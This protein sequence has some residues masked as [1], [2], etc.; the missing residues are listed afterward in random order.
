MLHPIPAIFEARPVSSAAILLRRACNDQPWSKEL[1]Q[2][3]HVGAGVSGPPSSAP[4]RL[5]KVTGKAQRKVLMDS[6]LN[7]FL[8]RS[9]SLTY[10]SIAEMKKMQA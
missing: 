2:Y 1:L 6:A 9:N 4:E 3:L 7:S 8:Y 10:Y 5:Q